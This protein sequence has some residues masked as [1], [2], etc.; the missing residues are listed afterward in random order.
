MLFP[1]GR[2][3]RTARPVCIGSF[4]S[5]SSRKKKKVPFRVKNGLS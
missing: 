2:L 1:Q 3:P 4:R 5:E